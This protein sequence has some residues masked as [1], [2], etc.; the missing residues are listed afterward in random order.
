MSA[1]VQQRQLS[2]EQLSPRQKAA[3][4]LLA[5]DVE[6][7]AKV[8]Q[9]LRQQDIEQV[10]VEIAALDA[11]PKEITAK[12]I[13]EFYNVL[14]S[15]E[16]M[17]TGGVEYARLLLERTFGPEKS[18]ELLEKVKML[19]TV[20][21]FDILKKADPQQLASFL[22]KEHPQTIALLLSHLPTNQSAEVL[23]RF[24][25]DL[26]TDVI[27]RIA[28]LGKV[29]PSIVQQIEQV[30]DQIAEQTLSQ[31]LATAGGAQIVASILNLSPPAIAKTIMEQIE[32]TNP[33]LAQDIKR[34]MFL[35]ED[36]L[37][38]DDRGIQRILR[39]VDRRDLVLAL[40]GAD[41]RLRAKIFKNMSERAAKVVKEELELMGPVKLKDVEAA[42]QRI[43]EVVKRLEE[44]EEITISGRGRDEVYI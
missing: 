33:Q 39:D 19:S 2:Y 27:I 30:V 42:Q 25:D 16:Y 43:V 44:Q 20:R 32:Q 23:E 5:L 6:T 41:E 35:F 4:L 34:M 28:T 8:F 14:V 29:S 40:R 12:V 17:L 36:I 31:N 22:S 15:R 21:G 26:R 18:R 10:S 3:L 38:I 24:P 13:E 37:L 7:A 9:G 11:V 1:I